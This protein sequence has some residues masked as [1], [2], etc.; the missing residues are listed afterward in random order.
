[1]ATDL[2]MSDDL[3]DLVLSK[4]PQILDDYKAAEED[5]RNGRTVSASEFFEQLELENG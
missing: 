3:E 1:M 2:E 5:A 4:A